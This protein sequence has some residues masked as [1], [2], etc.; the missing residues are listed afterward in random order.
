MPMGQM[1]FMFPI[2]AIGFVICFVVLGSALFFNR[3]IRSYRA[4]AREE[5][6]VEEDRRTQSERDKAEVIQMIEEA[7]E[8][9]KMTGSPKRHKA[10]VGTTPSSHTV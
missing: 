3:Y 5:D 8:R 1:D 10:H 2:V 6:V 4:R 9:H 7:L